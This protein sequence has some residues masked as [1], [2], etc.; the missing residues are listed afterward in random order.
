MHIDVQIS[1]AAPMYRTRN[2]YN[3]ANIPAFDLVQQVRIQSL[4]ID[5]RLNLAAGVLQHHKR[6]TLAHNP[7]CYSGPFIT[8][9]ESGLVHIRKSLLQFSR[10]AVGAK[11]IREGIAL[12][13]DCREL[14]A[15]FCDQS[16]FVLI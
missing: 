2:T 6:T 12:L 16:M 8:L 1:L 10:L 11:I 3:I 14:I 5:I 13:A 15:T 4:S 9:L 7:T